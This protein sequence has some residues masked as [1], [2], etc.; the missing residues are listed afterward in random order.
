MKN[1]FRMIILLLLLS[2]TLT[3]CSE[4]G[5]SDADR[6]KDV[7]DVD[8]PRTDAESAEDAHADASAADA[9]VDVDVDLPD[10]EV[11]PDADIPPV[12]EG[13]IVGGEPGFAFNLAGFENGAELIATT[14]GSAGFDFGDKLQAAPVLFDEVDNV[15]E[16]G[17]QNP[18]RD[19]HTQGQV[20][21]IRSENPN[22]V[23]AGRGPSG[24]IFFE[25]QENLRVPGQA[26]YRMPGA[27]TTHKDP[28]AGL[29]SPY[30]TDGDKT[31]YLAWHLRTKYH[32]N[33]YNRYVRDVNEVELNESTGFIGPNP[34]E[35]YGET[36]H[37]GGATARVIGVSEQGISVEFVDDTHRKFPDN[38]QVVGE[39]SGASFTARSDNPAG[40]PWNYYYQTTGSN[41]WLRVWSNVGSDP[42]LRVSWTQMHLTVGSDGSIVSWGE[43]T[44]DLVDNWVLMEFFLTQD[45]L[46]AKMDGE[47]VH[48]VDVSGVILPEG[49]KRNVAMLGFNGNETA[50]QIEQIVHISEVYLDFSLKRFYLANAPSIEE[51]TEVEL[52]QLTD[53]DSE[54]VKMKIRLGN[55]DPAS[56][57]IYL[58]YSDGFDET[59]AVALQ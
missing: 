50:T 17:V 46:I 35:R 13:P 31:M 12:N 18:V 54:S 24:P 55:L 7:A 59:A 27:S 23:Y 52:Q 6:P 2:M 53:W 43:K 39:T 19:D 42:P 1:L 40:G 30:P 58:I 32:A 29:A 4:N 9:Q 57:T 48:D 38:S 49:H 34:G 51:A 44:G 8:A 14:D 28:A 20:I 41:K 15:F 45:R 25:N 33:R 36:V 37:G 16:N 21:E 26:I 11:V 10:A 3:G 56:D 5:K 22:E 47:V